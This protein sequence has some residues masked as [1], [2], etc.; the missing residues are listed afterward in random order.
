MSLAIVCLVL[1]VAGVLGGALIVDSY[2]QAVAMQLASTILLVPA[3][4][5]VQHFLESGLLRRVTDKVEDATAEIAATAEGRQEPAASYGPA[6][7]ERIESALVRVGGSRVHRLRGGDGGADL[8][9]RGD[10]LHRIIV[11][12]YKS[13]PVSS[14]VLHRLAAAAE[15]MNG[16]DVRSMLITTTPLTREALRVAHDL[17][18]A[19][20]QWDDTFDD[21]AN[22]NRALLAARVLSGMP[23]E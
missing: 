2:W 7:Y 9:V 12:A 6:A 3:L 14:Q 23:A 17:G 4:V 21:D 10:R 13:A 8:E 16:R 20:Y 18:I 19:V 5:V 1:G 11:K 15:Q 22:A